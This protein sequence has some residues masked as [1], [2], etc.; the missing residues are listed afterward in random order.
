VNEKQSVV[1][2][3][4]SG[5]AVPNNAIISKFEKALGC[6]LPRQKKKKEKKDEE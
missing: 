2:D 5:K 6:K 3:Y 1:Q 4:E